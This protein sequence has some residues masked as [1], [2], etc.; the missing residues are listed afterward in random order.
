MRL[1]LWFGIV[2]LMYGCGNAK[3]EKLLKQHTWKV[4]DVSVPKGDAYN[5]TQH[6]QAKDLK[7]GY[8]SDAF[9]QFLDDQVFIATVAGK[10]DTGAYHL[11]SN[12]KILSITNPDGKRSSEHLVEIVHIDDTSF[13]MKVKSVDFKFILHTRPK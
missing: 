7:N 3:T 2:V 4:Y 1:G 13:N 11:L 12:G 5:N 6:T 9:Y 10:S 8:Y